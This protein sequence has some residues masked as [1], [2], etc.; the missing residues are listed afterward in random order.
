[1]SCLVNCV[2]DADLAAFV[3]Q[4]REAA[5]HGTRP[6]ARWSGPVDVNMFVTQEIWPEAAR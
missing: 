6:T 4:V 3:L 2:G 1:M 5:A